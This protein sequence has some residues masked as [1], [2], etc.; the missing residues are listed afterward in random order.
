MVYVLMQVQAEALSGGPRFASGTT[1][2]GNIGTFAGVL[3]PDSGASSSGLTSST[4]NSLG[5]FSID[6]PQTGLATGSFAY[7]DSGATYIGTITGVID[8]DT[9]RLRGIVRGTFAFSESFNFT[10]GSSV[11]VFAGPNGYANGSIDA[12]VDPALASFGAASEATRI[13]GKANL[14]VQSADPNTAQPVGP[15]RSLVLTVD[16]FRQSATVSTTS[17]NVGSLVNGSSTGSGA[18]G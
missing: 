12:T 18:G 5:L 13:T 9:L 16:G 15:V 7:F 3:L 14:D 6:S 1:A 4:S 2:G 8:P 17:T 10:G 11:V